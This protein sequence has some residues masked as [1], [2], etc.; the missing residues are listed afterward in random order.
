[1]QLLDDCWEEGAYGEKDLHSPVVICIKIYARCLVII[2]R[3]CLHLH[4]LGCH[5]LKEK[6]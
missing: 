4:S 2:Y 6:Y 1:M 3:Q 5:T